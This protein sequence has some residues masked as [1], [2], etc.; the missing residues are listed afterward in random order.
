M[1]R[2]F[3]GQ[4]DSLVFY[5]SPNRRQKVARSRLMAVVIIAAI[6]GSAGLIEAFQTRSAGAN[7]QVNG[8]ATYFPR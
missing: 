1:T 6:A 8:P 2:S 7:A 3:Q 5:N 4:T